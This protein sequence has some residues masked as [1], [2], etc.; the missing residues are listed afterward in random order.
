MA[1]VQYSFDMRRQKSVTVLM[2]QNEGAN[3]SQAITLRKCLVFVG[4]FGLQSLLISGQFLAG[5]L[6]ESLQVIAEVVNLVMVGNSRRQLG[7]EAGEIGETIVLVVCCHWVTVCNDLVVIS[8]QT[9]SNMVNAATLDQSNRSK[10]RRMQS[11]ITLTDWF[12]YARHTLMGSS[13]S[14]LRCHQDR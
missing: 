10:N 11:Q 1:E 6:Q 12:T 2:N 14:S 3:K 5:L 4:Q 9:V 7:L 8:S 13:G